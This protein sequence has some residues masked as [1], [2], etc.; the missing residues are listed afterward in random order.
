MK[1]NPIVFYISAS[2]IALFVLLGAL[3]SNEM[4]NAFAYIQNGIVENFGWF[5]I[6][7]VAF[8]LVFVLWL[9]VS[10]YGKVRLGKDDEEPHYSY[11]TWFAMLFS[12]GMGIGL[13][14]FGVAEPVSHFTNPPGGPNG[15]DP[16]TVESARQAINI[17]FFHWGLH[18]WAIY[19]VV[20]LSLAYFSYRHDLPLTLRS[21]F[22]PLLGNRIYGPIGHVVD[23]IAVFGTLFGL[24]TSLGLGVQQINAGTDY[25]G[26][27]DLNTTNQI[28]LIAAITAAA[29]ISVVT[30]VDVGIRRLS[31][32]NLVMAFLLL[33]FVFILGPTVFILS[34]FVQGS[35]TYISS[36]VQMT[37]K[38]D[39]FIGLDWQ[40]AW[41]MFY[42]GWWISWSPFV[43]M[44]IARVSR[45]RT[46]REFVIGV[47]LAPTLLTFF[48]MS[49]FGNTSIW[50]EMF[51][52][53]QGL[54]SE[55]VSSS[56][57]LP[58]AIFAM[59]QQLPLSL[60]SAGLATIV[61]AIFFVTSSDSGSLVVDILTSGGHPDPPIGQRVFWAITEGVVA[62]I[63]L[64][65]GGLL[66]LQTAA[67][68]TALPLCAV[69][70]IM[71]YALVKGLRAEKVTPDPIQNTFRALRKMPETARREIANLI[72]LHPTGKSTPEVHQSFIESNGPPERTP[73]NHDWKQRL[74]QIVQ[75][76]D[77]YFYSEPAS[78][79]LDAQEN[80]DDFFEETVVPAFEEISEQL[81]TNGRR[82]EISNGKE[83][84]EL[85]VYFG[86]QEEFV[87]AIVGHSREKAAFAFPEFTSQSKPRRATAEIV[88]R[89]GHRKEH[90][91]HKFT[92]DHIIRDF[93]NA[94]AKWMGW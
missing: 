22:Y 90:S 60:I 19:I 3:A 30:G 65:T 46:I 73:R 14:F 2:V 59:L 26:I 77:R 36:L 75:T 39:A 29:T 83:R 23:I 1:I 51:G 44:F 85:T 18:A 78:N 76:H 12:A 88:M 33:M 21:T 63:L 58:T 42:W 31:E 16:A 28:I 13:L 10:P 54:L 20:G 45:G 80:L 69:L 53:Q 24:A 71:C 15:P 4:S 81:E 70:L 40:K 48:W 84:L 91:T 72:T 7:S 49:V 35:G 82:V 52:D 9:M 67:I 93:T 5:Y 25:L 64:L 56:L 62:S 57:T 27:L 6:V 66:A 55:A 50:L 47:L 11:L 34:A 17:T 43:G 61:V 38:T 79:K 68:T 32:A 8:F 89:S 92:K 86:D 74:S 41:T 37:F 94:Y 87:Y